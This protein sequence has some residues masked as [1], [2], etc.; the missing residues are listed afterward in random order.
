MESTAIRHQVAYP[1]LFS[2]CKLFPADL[3]FSEVF[4]AHLTPHLCVL[5][6]T[7][8]IQSIDVLNRRGS[9]SKL[10][11]CCQLHSISDQ[12]GIPIRASPPSLYLAPEIALLKLKMTNLEEAGSKQSDSWII[13]L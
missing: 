2:A 1:R 4:R 12:F 8:V 11:L 7:Y 6:A 10:N 9:S 5:V 3:G 13:F